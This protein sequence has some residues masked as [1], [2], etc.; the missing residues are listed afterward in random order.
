[1]PSAGIA[2]L[3][4]TALKQHSVS[5]GL[6]FL[7]RQSQLSALSHP[8]SRC[9]RLDA[10]SSKLLPRELRQARILAAV[11]AIPSCQEMVLF[12][13]AQDLQIHFTG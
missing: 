8:T 4:I 10:E 5:P 3:V 9:C 13:F 2:M 12:V 6:A 7:H 11:P 1:M